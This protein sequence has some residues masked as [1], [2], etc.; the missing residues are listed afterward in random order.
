MAFKGRVLLYEASPQFNPSNP[1]DNA[2]WKNAYEANKM[3][4]ESLK[5]W[6]YGLYPDYDGIWLNEQNQEDVMTVV[7]M[8]PGKTNGREAGVR[9]LSVSKNATGWDQPIWAL[10]KSYPMADGKQPSQSSKYSYDI[11]TYW[12]DRDPRFYATIIYNGEVVPWG[13]NASNRQYTDIQVGGIIDGF[14]D[15]ESYQRTG[16]YCKKGIDISLPQAQVGL[17][18]IDWVEIR[19][20]EVLLN[21]A[22]A[23]NETGHPDEAVTV[24]KEIRKRAGIDPGTDEM[25]GLKSGMSR[26]ELRNAIHFERYI[27]FAFEGKRFWDLRRWREFPVIDGM[28]KYGLEAELKSGIEPTNDNSL[29]PSDFN[30]TVRELITSGFKVMNVPD[31]YYFFPISEGEIEK[32][33]KLEQNKDWGGS[34]DP[35][36]H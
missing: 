16:F 33:P 22:E 28:R 14:G 13:G 2:Y 20:A 36:L 11:Q 17:N 6:G 23:A 9:P 26:S 31:S 8:D 34:F 3:A 30:Y 18:A 35:T 15:L 1:Y 32:D 29:L 19:F 7:Y 24:L 25:Y 5:S 12:K 10:V 4:V 27:E 21:Y